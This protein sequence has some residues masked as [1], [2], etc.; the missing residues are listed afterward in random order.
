MK[1][2]IWKE[3]RETRMIPAAFCLLFLA[4]NLFLITIQYLADHMHGARVTP[5]GGIYTVDSVKLTGVACSLLAAV[6]CGGSIVSSEASKGTMSFLTSL[7]VPKKSLWLVKAGIGFAGASAALLGILLLGLALIWVNF[8][9]SAIAI[10]HQDPLAFLVM[11]TVLMLSAF[12]AVY[13]VSYAVSCLN[14]QTFASIVF[15]I[16]AC[17]AISGAGF[18]M[19]LLLD[20]V[21]TQKLSEFN[22]HLIT[23]HEFDY[24]LALYAT[25]HNPESMIVAT[26]FALLTLT[27]IALHISNVSFGATEEPRRRYLIPLRIVGKWTAVYAS[28]G[29]ALYG[30][31]MVILFHVQPALMRQ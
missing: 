24:Y 4:I 19:I 30:L 6:V 5:P 27:V 17:F 2:L 9:W 11:L 18:G 3:W 1:T 16:L 7:P 20:G 26:S 21:T 31:Y 13:A 8:G 25:L 15:A 29:A 12:T 14:N 28:L 22:N 23:L 10:A